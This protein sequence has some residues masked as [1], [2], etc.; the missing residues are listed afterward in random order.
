M[1]AELGRLWRRCGEG[2]CFEDV[3]VRSSSLE[4]DR[5]RQRGAPVIAVG[6][7]TLHRRPMAMYAEVGRLWRQRCRTGRCA[8]AVAVRSSS[9]E[10]DLLRQRGA[11]DLAARP[12]A[13]HRRPNSICARLAAYGGLA[14]YERGGHEA[15]R[16]IAVVVQGQL[17]A[18][19]GL[20][21]P[22]CVISTA[23]L[24]PR[25][26]PSTPP[27]KGHQR[28]DR[29]HGRRPG[30]RPAIIEALDRDLLRQ[31]FRRPSGLVSCWQLSR[32]VAASVSP[33]VP[34]ACRQL[35]PG[36]RRLRLRLAAGWLRQA[37]TLPAPPAGSCRSLPATRAPA[38]GRSGF[39]WPGGGRACARSMAELRAVPAAWRRVCRQGVAAAPPRRP[40]CL[41]HRLHV[42]RP[43][44]IRCRHLTQLRA[45]AGISLRLTSLR[46]GKH[47]GSAWRCRLASAGRRR[48][49]HRE[50]AFLPLGHAAATVAESTGCRRRQRGWQER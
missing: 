6:P 34:A 14:I 9:L 41:R 45:G 42:P 44:G 16:P 50:R 29:R 47:P 35:L 7:R 8:E 15:G 48:H 37:G 11:P 31:L 18:G 17:D 43:T 20:G 46:A 1:Y 39:G 26:P 40:E 4:H 10:H 30:L 38:C 23:R 36:E 25:L 33:A 27:P 28:R 22:D 12:R 32:I 21:P 13:L 3:A 24:T 19:A 2:R 5:L 49:G